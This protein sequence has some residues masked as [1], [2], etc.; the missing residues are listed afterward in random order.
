MVSFSTPDPPRQIADAPDYHK[1]QA[2]V[3]SG[4]MGP[5]SLAPVHVQIMDYILANPHVNYAEVAA[6]FGY[7]QGWLSQIVHSD[8]FQAMLAEKQVELF[9]DLR[10]TIKDRVTGLAH[11]SLKRLN[12]RVAVETDT[13]KLTDVADLALKALGF[14]AKSPQAAVGT[15]NAHNVIVSAVDP[16]TLAAARQLMHQPKG[17]EKAIEAPEA[18]PAPAQ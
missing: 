11:E 2:P 15:I 6:H 8:A 16:Q 10:V 17:Q 12:E 3:C 14:G 1:A 13:E 9:G 4:V 18:L 5:K 7:T